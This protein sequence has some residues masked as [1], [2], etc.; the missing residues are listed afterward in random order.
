MRAIHIYFFLILSATIFSCGAE[1]TENIINNS[2]TLPDK[3][4]NNNQQ[5]ITDSLLGEYRGE[6]GKTTIFLNLSYINLD[7]GSAS[8]YNIVRGNRRNIKGN[9]EEKDGLLYFKLSEPGN[10]EHDGVFDFT[11]NPATHEIEGTWTPNDNKVAQ[12]RTI[13]LKKIEK[14]GPDDMIDGEWFLSYEIIN[15]DE[16]AEYLQGFITFKKDGTCFIKINKW[17]EAS[18]RNITEEIKGSWIK[19]NKTVKLD[20]QK[21]KIL[22]KQKFVLKYKVE[23][24]EFGYGYYFGDNLTISNTVY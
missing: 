23:S 12:A 22:K 4:L 11:L 21:N 14:T 9:V 3:Q 24:E 8:G 5:I 18:D 15:N 7:N 10:H 2:D 6:F 17:D 1:K 19:E 20:I 16:V 13:K